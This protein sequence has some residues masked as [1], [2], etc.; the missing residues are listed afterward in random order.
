[1]LRASHRFCGMLGPLTAS[2]SSIKVVAYARHPAPRADWRSGETGCDNK[3][4]PILSAF[5]NLN[6]LPHAFHGLSTWIVIYGQLMQVRRQKSRNEISLSPL[7]F[8][9]LCISWVHEVVFLSISLIIFQFLHRVTCLRLLDDGREA[10]RCTGER[11]VAS[12]PS[13]G[14]LNLGRPNMG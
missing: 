12:R 2:A 6:W 9:Y 7:S 3:R 8:A 14:R 1:V 5:S 11:P 4:F 13:R 10:D